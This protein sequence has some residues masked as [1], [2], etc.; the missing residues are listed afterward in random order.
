MIAGMN[1]SLFLLKQHHNNISPQLSLL[2][3]ESII[4][5]TM[6]PYSLHPSDIF[7]DFCL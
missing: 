1:G 4:L 5:E 3:Y 2:N 7:C 6:S